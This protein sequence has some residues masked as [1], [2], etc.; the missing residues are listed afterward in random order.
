MG[1]PARAAT[2]DGGTTDGLSDA[3][4]PGR[5]DFKPPQ[6]DVRIALGTGILLGLSSTESGRSDTV[7]EGYVGALDTGIAVRY[8]W[9]SVWSG[10]FRASWGM[11]GNGASE[12]IDRN[13][14]QLAAEGRWQ[15]EGEL[16]PYAT[17]GAGAALVVDSFG[18][19]SSWQWA[20]LLSGA[21]GIDVASVGPVAFGAELRGAITVFGDAGERFEA[22]GESV[23]NA[24]GVVPWLGINLIATL[25][26]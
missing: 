3:P 25:G 17:L 2:G 12:Q 19:A 1:A 6:H 4:P 14:W 16:G 26:I 24:Y 7:A 23:S 15:P 5:F 22:G 8:Q 13:L 20:P 10:G 21:L 9:P 11:S 18:G